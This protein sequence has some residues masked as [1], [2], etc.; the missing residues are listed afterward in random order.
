MLQLLACVLINYCFYLCSF[1]CCCCEGNEHGAGCLLVCDAVCSSTKLIIVSKEIS[2][3]IFR[4]S[5]S[6]LQSL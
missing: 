4:V 2:V 1:L 6:T 5:N 3:S